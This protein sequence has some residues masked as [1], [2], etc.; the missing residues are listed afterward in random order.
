MAAP[1]TVII[2][3]DNDFSER[4]DYLFPHDDAKPWF[5]SIKEE[6][7]FRNGTLQGAYLIMAARAVGLDT[8]PMSGFDNVMVDAEF[9]AGTE[10][11]SNFIC[12]LGY[13][14][15]EKLFGRLPRFNFDDVCDVL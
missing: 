3:H 12:S 5:A 8:G 9:F 13:G 14:D 4:L 2:A 10:I 11:K 6:T 1:A 7:A 15:P